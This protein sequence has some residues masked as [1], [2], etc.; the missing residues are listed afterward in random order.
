[1]VNPE[2]VIETLNKL[3]SIGVTLSL[4]DFGTG[5]SSLAYLSRFPLDALKIDRSFIRDV[6]VKQEATTLADSIIALAQ[7]MRLRVVAEGVETEEQLRF[8]RDRDCDELQGYYISK[9]L[10]AGQFAEIVKTGLPLYKEI[11]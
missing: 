5:Y 11:S 10:P 7:R 1:M 3:K 4:D 6:I 9:P 2:K 8:L